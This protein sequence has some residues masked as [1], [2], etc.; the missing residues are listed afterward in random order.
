MAFLR[1][2]DLR[3]RQGEYSQARLAIES[4]RAIGLAL[5][6]PD[7]LTIAERWLALLTHASG[8]HK[9]ARSLWNG[10][11]ERAV[12]RS[13]LDMDFEE[14]DTFTLGWWAL[15]EGDY[16]QAQRLL[17]RH[18][19]LVLARSD[20]NAVSTVARPL[21]YALLYQGDFAQAAARLRESLELNLALGSQQAAA[22]CLAAFGALALARADLAGSARL[23]GASE[24]ACESIHTPLMQSDE[25]EVRRNTAILRERMDPAA[26]VAA[27]A[28]GQA[29]TLDEAVACARADADRL[30]G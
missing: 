15:A 23:F 9:Q 28:E 2:A 16:P 29:M 22:A 25:V 26:L 7:I 1:A 10:V 30:T 4:A 24:A 11:R 5:D 27:W 3:T 6:D 19:D 13:R 21:G 17:A 18:Y 20:A 14:E 8:D 12:A